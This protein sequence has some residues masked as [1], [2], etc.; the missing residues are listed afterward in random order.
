MGIN[1]VLEIINDMKSN[2]YIPQNKEHVS[3]YL[4]GRVEF[5]YENYNN[6]I[7]NVFG[8]I[9][10]LFNANI[11][12]F[13]EVNSIL[14]RRLNTAKQYRNL[15][16]NMISNLICPPDKDRNLQ[17]NKFLEVLNEFGYIE[18]V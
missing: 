15:H 11:N 12:E 4:N 10:Y 8:E 6:E 18:K 13:L 9:D 14:K 7:N 5:F 2:K 3:N 16:K 1:G 17:Y